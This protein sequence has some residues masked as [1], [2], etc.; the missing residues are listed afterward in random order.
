M[1]KRISEERFDNKRMLSVVEAQEYCGLGRIQ[2][3]RL[4]ED[5]GA[6]RRYGRRVL[7][8]RAILDKALDSLPG[9]AEAAEN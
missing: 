5:C 6:V 8:E 2:T 3:R 1:R 9:T 7:I 4:A